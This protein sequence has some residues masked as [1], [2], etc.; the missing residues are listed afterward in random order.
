[1]KR[2]FSAQTAAIAVGGLAVVLLAAWYLLS[3]PSQGRRAADLNEVAHHL[4]AVHG[5][6][7]K[8]SS[9]DQDFVKKH[10]HAFAGAIKSGGGLP[11]GSN[12][13]EEGK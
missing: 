13:G 4:S 1:M 9:S 7:S 5:D 10:F 8:L 6:L 2:E 3:G 11:Q 12:A